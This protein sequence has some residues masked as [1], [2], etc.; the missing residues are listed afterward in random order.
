LADD[1]RNHLLHYR[2]TRGDVGRLEEPEKDLLAS[3][4]IIHHQTEDDEPHQ[5]VR[6]ALT[7]V[8]LSLA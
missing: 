5:K 2:L 7:A 3:E 6:W 1:E 8:G 4:L